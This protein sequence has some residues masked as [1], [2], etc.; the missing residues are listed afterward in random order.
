MAMQELPPRNELERAVLERDPE[1]DGL[2]YVG[3]RTTGIF[4]RPTCPARKPLARNMRFFRTPAEALFA[5]FRACLRCRPLE[6]GEA[7]PGWVR[8]LLARVDAAPHERIRARDLRARG[9][10][11]AAARRYFQRRYGMTFAAWCRSRR[12]AASLESLRVGA[13]VDDAVAGSGYESHSGYRAAFAR[14]FGAPPGRHDEV[15]VMLMS[16]IETPL[17][18]MVAGATERG[19]C[20]LE[21]TDRRMLEAQLETL[22]TRLRAR[23]VPGRNVHLDALERGLAAYFDGSG[24][25][26]D[27]PLDFPGSEFQRAVWDALLRIPYGETRS[28]V[29]LARELGRPGGAR[30]IGRANGQNRIAIVIPCHRVVNE[31]GRLGGYGGGLARK[32]FLLDMEREVGGR[33]GLSRA[34]PL[35]RPASLPLDLGMTR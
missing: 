25:R 31:D 7:A 22:A 9:V 35:E 24:T 3:V 32:Q 28:Y 21:F 4:C 1:W 17:G 30:A 29:A 13:S 19:A 27:V 12:L 8:G 15:Q 5:G 26:F 18:A 23:L 14:A 34:G 6:P 33:L 20:L 2:F 10:D 11:P 16:M